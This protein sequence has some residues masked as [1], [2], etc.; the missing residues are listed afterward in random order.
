M[1]ARRV[2][3]TL[4]VV[5]PASLSGIT[6]A[7][8]VGASRALGETMLV[9]LVAGGSSGAGRVFAPTE[10]GL[11]MTAGMASL[12]AGSDNV[13]TSAVGTVNP[14]DSLYLVGLVL[15]VATL[16]L[17]M[18]GDRMVRKYRQAY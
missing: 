8:I 17:N 14:V 12:A 1:G 3:T 2:T 6:A 11:T 4:R 18:L 9:M 7:L 10:G 15:F 13:A 5:L 16:V